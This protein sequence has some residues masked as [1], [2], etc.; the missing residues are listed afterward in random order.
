MKILVTGATGFIGQHL[1]KRLV[2]KGLSV[3]VIIRKESDASNIDSSVKIF[4]YANNIDTLITLFQNERFDGVIHLASLFLASHKSQE[5]PSLI[6][7]NIQYGTELLEASKLTHTKWFINTGTF[8]QHYRDEPYNPVNLYAA[9]KQAFEDIAKYYTETS[10]LIFTTLKLNDTFG[11]DDTRNKIFNLW[12]HLSQTDDSLE[13][14]PGE[15][16]IDICFIEDV[17]DAYEVLMEHIMHNV[18][19]VK[20]KTFLIHGQNTMS[21]RALSKIFEDSTGTTLN[22][23]WGGKEYREREVMTPCKHIETLPGWKPRHTLQE[24]IKKTIRAIK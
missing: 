22:I 23:H 3:V 12:H 11:P 6:L 1:I 2:E 24:A 10:D 14:S 19:S 7:S 16:M 15:Q 18:Q 4:R 9:T 13:M 5:I 8:W 20:N 17:I 21:L